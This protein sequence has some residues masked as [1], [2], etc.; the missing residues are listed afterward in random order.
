MNSK[1]KLT[2]VAAFIVSSAAPAFA[3]DRL[4]VDSEQYGVVG[5]VQSDAPTRNQTTAPAVNPEHAATV[6]ELLRHADEIR[7]QAERL[8]R[9]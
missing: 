3:Q 8:L 6:N 9:P 2:L 4:S 7:Y 1:T 5:H